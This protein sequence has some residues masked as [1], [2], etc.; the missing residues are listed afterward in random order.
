MKILSTGNLLGNTNKFEQ[1]KGITNQ[2]KPDILLI[3]G[4]LFDENPYSPLLQADFLDECK[5]YFKYYA[6]NCENLL[7]IFGETDLGCLEKTFE[8]LVK[9][10]KNN[11]FCL[12]TENFNYNDHSFIGIP[13]V[14]N[15]K[16]LLKDWSHMD[17][18]S[19]DD[20]DDSCFYSDEEFNLIKIDDLYNYITSKDTLTKI[21]DLKLKN[22]L[23]NKIVVSHYPPFNIYENNYEYVLYLNNILDDINILYTGHTRSLFKDEIKK[24]N[25]CNIINCGFHKNILLYNI[26]IV[27]NGIL[28]YNFHPLINKTNAFNNAYIYRDLYDN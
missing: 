11:I 17:S 20:T 22:A 26:N 1:L 19:F 25:N 23:K 9:T 3:T 10:E 21:I 2:I 27:E 4:D 18:I 16:S 12:N 24:H 15:T 5:E 6:D 8:D 28:T 7:Y 14:G 13:Q